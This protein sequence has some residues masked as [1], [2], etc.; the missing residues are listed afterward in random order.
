M[1]NQK[2]LE[3]RF[4]HIIENVNGGKI[5]MNSMLAPEV[6]GCDAEKLTAI[7]SA[8]AELQSRKY[9]YWDEPQEDET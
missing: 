7:I 3:E 9:L 1:Y 6:C 4:D 2:E 8:I 5:N